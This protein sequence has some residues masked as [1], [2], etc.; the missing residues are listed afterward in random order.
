[1][2]QQ[3]NYKAAI[4]QLLG[5]TGPAS[6]KSSNTSRSI[7]MELLVWHE[8]LGSDEEQAGEDELLRRVLY[9]HRD[10]LESDGEGL[11]PAPLHALH[12]LQGLVAFVRALRR[13]SDQD[14]AGGPAWVSVSLAGRR[15]LVLEVEPAV[16]MAMVRLL[17]RGGERACGTAGY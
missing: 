6:L 2:Q 9:R 10:G 15:L 11:E 14:Q 8:A 1:M 13:G 17:R 5:A 16:F 4:Y 3:S 7:T 12:L